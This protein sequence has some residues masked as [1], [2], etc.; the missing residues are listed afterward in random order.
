LQS[1]EELNSTLAEQFSEDHLYRIDHYLGKEMVQNLTVLRFSNTWFERVWNSNDIQCVI[2]TL[3]EPFGTEGRGGYFDQYGIIRDILQNHL[4]QVMTLLAMEP[5]TTVDGPGAGKAIRDAKVAVLNAIP[6][7]KLEDVIL[8]QYEGYSDDE[9]ILN[10]D[11]N[12]PTFAMVRMFINNPRWHGVP[13]V[14]K[15][16]KA[17]DEHKAEMRIQFKDAPAATYLFAGQDCPRNELVMRLQP[18]EAVYMKTNVKSPGFAAKPVQSELEVNYDTRFFANDTMVNPDAYTRLI[19]DVLQGKHAAFVRDDELRQAWRIFTPLLHQIDNDNIQPIIYTQSSRGPKE[20]DEYITK[21]CGYKRNE[22]YVFYD[23]GV[24][25]KTEGTTVA[26]VRQV[27]STQM[28]IAEEDKAEIGL[29][30]LAVM[31]QNFSLNIASHG[32]KIC[33]GNRSHE[34]VEQT[35]ARAKAEGHLPLIGSDDVEHFVAQLKKPRKVIILVQAGKPVDDM[36]SN[37]AVYM[38]PGDLIVDGGNEWFPNSIRRAEFL[39]PSGIHFIGMGISGG[40][41]GARNGPS[42]MPG[43]P[44]EAYDMIVPILTKCAAQVE[45]TGACVGYVGPVGSGNYVKM[46]HNGIEYGDLQLIAEVYD[47]LKVSGFTLNL[48][49]CCDD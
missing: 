36:I 45:R 29:W 48:I 1:F 2:L 47:V 22:D 9:T 10:K 37:L 33:V 44:R 19:L 11:T 42:L 16:G 24:A 8:G 28:D 31:G 12:C 21:M 15:A 32:F 38:E 20:A 4:L 39:E 46:V 40:E 43:G 49:V 23:D 41:E 27:G 25:R 26:P 6:P 7:I 17:L 14:L 3:K 13:F 35:V 30:G 18:G 34:K 5:P